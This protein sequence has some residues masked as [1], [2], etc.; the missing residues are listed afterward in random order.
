MRARDIALASGLDRHERTA[1]VAAAREDEA[2]VEERHP[3][4][5][6]VRLLDVPQP[7]AG[8]EVVSADAGTGVHDD[9]GLAAGFDYQW[10]A[11]RRG[12]ALG[13]HFPAH[14]AGA[15]VEREQVGLALVV[16]D[17]DQRV[18]VDRR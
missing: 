2:V 17:K 13:V 11:V 1:P 5:E 7:G 16:A 18:A 15:R 4:R 12:A 14:V 8:S 10:R 3:D 6:T 9:L